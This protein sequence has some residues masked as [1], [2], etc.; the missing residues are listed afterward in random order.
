MVDHFLVVILVVRCLLGRLCGLGVA[1]AAVIVF[2]A[3]TQALKKHDNVVLI[4]DLVFSIAR[5]NIVRGIQ[6]SKESS[7]PTGRF[8]DGDSQIKKL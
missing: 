5:D 3:G 7:V 1:L 6:R 2:D 4:F 8:N